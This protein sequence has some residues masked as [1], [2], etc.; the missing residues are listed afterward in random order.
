MFADVG[1]TVGGRC[2]GWEDAYF[3]GQVGVE[4]GWLIICACLVTFYA[5]AIPA[6]P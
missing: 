1:M 6:S 3:K 5:C 2:G 4:Y